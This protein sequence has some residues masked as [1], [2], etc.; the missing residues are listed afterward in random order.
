MKVHVVIRFDPMQ[1]G[2]CGCG[3]LDKIF[4][5][6]QEA[7]AYVKDSSKRRGVSWVIKEK[8]VEIYETEKAIPA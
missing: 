4:M 5:T 8:S 3:H 7:Q 1:C 6:L 2:A